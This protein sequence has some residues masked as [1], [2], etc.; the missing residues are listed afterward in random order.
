MIL[1]PAIDNPVLIPGLYSNTCLNTK[2][3]A[4]LYAVCVVVNLTHVKVSLPV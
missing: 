2:K 3:G 4:Q 1:S